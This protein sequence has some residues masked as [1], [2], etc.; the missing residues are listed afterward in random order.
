MSSH[1][2]ATT[3]RPAAS[4]APRCCGSS[5]RATAS[6]RPSTTASAVLATV[7]T[8][9]LPPTAGYL[10][11]EHVD[12]RARLGLLDRARRAGARRGSRRA[13]RDA[14]DP[15][16]PRPHRGRRDRAG[17]R[18][19]AAPAPSASPSELLGVALV[20]AVGERRVQNQPGT[21]RVPELAGAA[22]RTRRGGRA[23]SR[24][25]RRTSGSGRSPPPSTRRCAADRVRRPSRRARA[26]ALLTL[27]PAAQRR[28]S[29]Q[30]R[31]DAAAAR[32]EKRRSPEMC[33]GTGARQRRTAGPMGWTGRSRVRDC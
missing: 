21:T 27:A 5:T 4:S 14:V 1:G 29:A 19:G 33:R 7:N 25:S 31:T 16:R 3:S 17:D 24:I 13:R 2:C 8:H 12:L 23:A 15:A 18:R 26:Q 30:R 20:D 9:D 22:R 11:G 6:R 32:P 28:R 10:A